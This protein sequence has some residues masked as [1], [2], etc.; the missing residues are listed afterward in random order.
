[1]MPMHER[2]TRRL[3][4]VLAERDALRA[5]LATVNKLYKE[6]CDAS[7]DYAAMRAENEALRQDAERYRWL[8]ARKD[9]RMSWYASGGV[10]DPVGTM[11][12]MDSLID[13][14]IDA[15]KGKTL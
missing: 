9:L 5:E 15:A 8:R 7:Y 10:F 11:G 6:S 14:A 12:N 4:E 13:A 2:L 3:D 1:M